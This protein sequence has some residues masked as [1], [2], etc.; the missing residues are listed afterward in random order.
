MSNRKYSNF[1]FHTGEDNFWES[2]SWRAVFRAFQQAESAT[3][4]GL[5]NYDGANYEVIMSK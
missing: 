1:I 2:D 4:Y 5:P 3:I